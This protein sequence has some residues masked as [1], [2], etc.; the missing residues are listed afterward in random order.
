[1]KITMEVVS[2]KKKKQYLK[3]IIEIIKLKK[4]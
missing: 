1:M 2:K 3:N 4:K